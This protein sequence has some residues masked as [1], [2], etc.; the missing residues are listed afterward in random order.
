MF[1]SLTFSLF[2]SLYFL[3]FLYFTVSLSF[4][5][6]VPPVSFSSHSQ[7]FSSLPLHFSA[8]NISLCHSLL[9]NICPFLP[10]FFQVDKLKKFLWLKLK[11]PQSSIVLEESYWIL[12]KR[13]IDRSLDCAFMNERITCSKLD[14]FF[15]EYYLNC[16]KFWTCVQNLQRSRGK[17][18]RIRILRT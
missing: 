16:T 11:N 18:Y 1:R 9:Q 8:H 15:T 5:F 13:Y 4:P 17:H 3:L 6:S 14:V 7:V 10:T 12:I 2:L